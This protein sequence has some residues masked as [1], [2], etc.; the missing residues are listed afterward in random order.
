MYEQTGLGE[1]RVSRGT[2]PAGDA[3]TK[4]TLDMMREL[5]EEG[6]RDLNVRETAIA[7]VKSVGAAAHDTIAELQ[8]LFQFVRDHV[9]FT[10]DILGVE[11]LQ[12]AAY[13]L[14]TRAGD[15]DDRA[16]LLVALAHSIGIPADFAFKVVALKSSNPHAF[17]HVFVVANVKGK[18]IALDPTY[19]VN[20]MGW[21]YPNPFRS[22]EVPA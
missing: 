9:R 8:A 14:R 11:T 4:K 7:I 10:N 19:Q 21:Q 6:A 1:H 17:S 16:V 2:L 5:A 13:T 15:C 3:G 18:R 22:A 20:P 12:G